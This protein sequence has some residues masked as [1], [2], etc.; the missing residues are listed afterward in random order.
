MKKPKAKR[1]QLFIPFIKK[2]RFAFILIFVSFFI[3]NEIFTPD[4]VTFPL[5]NVNV[6]ME[7]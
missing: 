5:L 3:K 7:R 2:Y 4:P 6:L 1:I